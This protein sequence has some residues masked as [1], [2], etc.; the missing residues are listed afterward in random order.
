MCIVCL[1][2]FCL[3]F[4]HL[5]Q[6]H[7]SFAF[8]DVWFTAGSSDWG[9]LLCIGSVPAKRLRESQ[10]QNKEEEKRK[11]GEQIT[12]QLLLLGTEAV[13]LMEQHK[14][15]HRAAANQVSCQETQMDPW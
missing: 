11:K 13:F 14:R 10:K 7:M 5:R 15:T 6:I 4:D 12:E 2:H 3:L 1:F 8:V 9:R